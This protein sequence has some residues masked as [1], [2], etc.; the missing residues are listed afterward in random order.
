MTID[1]EK[2]IQEIDED[3]SGQIDFEE[4]QHLLDGKQ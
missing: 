2:L 3:N 4:F 1:I